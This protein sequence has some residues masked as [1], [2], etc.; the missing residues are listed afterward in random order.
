MKHRDYLRK[1][2][3][4]GKT[5]A[6]PLL[7][8]TPYNEMYVKLTIG[9]WVD[10]KEES[11]HKYAN[12]GMWTT[13]YLNKYTDALSLSIPVFHVVDEDI[14]DIYSVYADTAGF[15]AEHRIY[16]KFK[17]SK[18]LNK[19]GYSLNPRIKDFDEQ[20]HIDI[21]RPF[22]WKEIDLFAQIKQLFS[23]NKDFI[24]R[25]HHEIGNN[26]VKHYIDKT[27]SWKELAEYEGRTIK[28]CKDFWCSPRRKFFRARGQVRACRKSVYQ[29]LINLADD[30]SHFVG[31]EQEALEIYFQGKSNNISDFC[32]LMHHVFLPGV[33]H[34]KYDM[35]LKHYQEEWD[36]VNE[37]D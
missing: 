27:N 28:A 34:T 32:A 11:A 30:L 37:T 33:D 10:E 6:C 14:K 1:L 22:Y 29:D 2:P 5:S 19:L 3:I 36:R 17:Y 21:G 23:K 18:Y 35:W 25:V 12:A 31:Y 13:H 9:S 8:K 20:L 26:I 16:E 15:P 24:F 7:P 4:L